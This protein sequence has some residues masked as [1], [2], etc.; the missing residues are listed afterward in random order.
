MFILYDKVEITLS[1]SHNTSVWQAGNFERAVDVCTDESLGWLELCFLYVP[2]N[3]IDGNSVTCTLLLRFFTTFLVIAFVVVVVFGVFVC[4]FLSSQEPQFVKN[5]FS[6]LEST[7]IYEPQQHSF[8][9]F[10]KI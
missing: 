4:L 7:A 2:F 9:V 3:C 1:E 5:Q 6:R 8:Y 10:L